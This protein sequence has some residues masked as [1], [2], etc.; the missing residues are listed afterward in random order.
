MFDDYLESRSVTPRQSL[1]AAAY[2]I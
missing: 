2:P 1:A